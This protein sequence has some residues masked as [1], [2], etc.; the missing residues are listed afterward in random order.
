MKPKILYFITKSNWGGAQK[1]VFDLSTS[2]MINNAFE[3]VVA[4][5]GDGELVS[6]IKTETLAKNLNIKII[7]LKYLGNSLN[8]IKL[9]LSILENIK[10]IRQESK[11]KNNK[12][13]EI[14]IHTNSSFAG[15][16][17]GVAS[18]LLFKKNVFT[19]HGWPYNE[20]RGLLQ[21]VILRIAMFAVLLMHKRLI[22][23]S[24]ENF[25]QS[26]FKWLKLKYKSKITYNGVE[27]LQD[28]EYLDFKNID[29]TFLSSKENNILNIVT[30][31]EL[32][33]TKNY[34][35]VLTAIGELAENFVIQNN[36]HYHIISDGAEKEN[37]EKIIANHKYKN[38]IKMHGKV[39]NA[40]KYLK[41]FDIFI[42]GSIS[43]G[44]AY[45]I[46]E[47]G[48]AGVPVIATRVGGIPE[49]INDGV[50]GLLVKSENVLDLKNKI[51]ILVQ[52]K[53]LRERLA[54]EL[55]KKVKNNFSKNKMIQ[56]TM[57]VYNDL[58]C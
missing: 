5:G 14:I 39:V 56:E 16:S 43:E 7:N 8:P 13:Q 44:L 46:L 42:L 28:D 41:A 4:V 48:R 27:N 32:H 34:P 26:P 10:I 1:Y 17:I 24:K 47:A 49:V 57:I 35:F 45:V 33:K 9:F 19:G 6:K 23:V 12:K 58:L 2:A 20:K 25:N 29:K 15:L 53:N 18:F 55:S 40:A 37:L 31:A 21:K 54:T 51:E 11:D 52:D 38:R 22:F 36:I 50:N 30:I 3:V